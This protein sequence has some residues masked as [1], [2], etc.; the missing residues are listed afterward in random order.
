[1]R[2]R[3]LTGAVLALLAWPATGHAQSGGASVP[4][5]TG[6]ANYGISVPG[7]KAS[8]FKVAP[9]TITLG[10][11]ISFRYRVD[12]SHQSVRVR[13][14]L[15]PV[16]SRHPAARIRMGWKRTGR[17][18]TRSWTPPAGKLTPGDYLARLHAVDRQ[19][20]TLRRSATA[21]GRSRLKVVAPAPPPAPIGAPAPVAP[22]VGSGSFPVQGRYTYGDRFG[23]DRGTAKHRGQDILAAQGTRVV[24]PRAGTVTWRA[25]QA[26]GAGYYVVVHAD[27]GRDFVF[28]HL[29]DGSITVAKGDTLTAGQA[30]AQVGQTGRATAPHLHFEIWPD[31]WYA[32]DAS[33]PLDPRPDLEAWAA[34]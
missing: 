12:G 13:V 10:A 26:E 20:R 31:G 17:T 11:P 16:G 27:D 1:M 23:A 25:Y 19:G 21:S 34:G 29:L 30:F 4:A 32:S 15:L 8:R 6:G 9:R 28:M 14:E 18:L 3:L 7:L 24:T 5:P 2:H 22:V 33:Q